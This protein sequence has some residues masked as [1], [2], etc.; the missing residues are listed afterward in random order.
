MANREILF[1]GKAKKADVWFE[2]NLIRINN[3]ECERVWI[4][5]ID[6]KA[7]EGAEVDP[8]TVGQYIGLTDN[9]G[10][11]IFEGDIIEISEKGYIPETILGKVIYHENAFKIWTKCKYYEKGLF[12][13]F[14]T[15][16]K[17]NEGHAI[18]SLKRKFFVIGNIYDHANIKLEIIEERRK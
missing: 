9:G 17:F 13:D 11:R 8:K 5:S 18:I 6:S 15:E 10:K 12:Y 2:G 1:R 4:K 7:I 16:D 14:K 3:G